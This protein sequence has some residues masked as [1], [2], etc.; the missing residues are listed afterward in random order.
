MTFS[1]E[2]PSY[3]LFIDWSCISPYFV[4][5]HMSILITTFLDFFLGN[6]PVKFDKIWNPILWKSNNEDRKYNTWLIVIAVVVN[7]III[8]A[9]VVVVVM[10]FRWLRWN[11]HSNFKDQ[12]QKFLC[13]E[14]EI[15]RGSSKLFFIWHKMDVYMK[16]A[17][18]TIWLVTRGYLIGCLIEKDA[19]PFSCHNYTQA[20]EYKLKIES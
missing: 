1:H 8:I 20:W 9:I 16:E 15:S 4:S 6:H 14:D 17:Y 2:E 10:V 13:K 5:Q 7:I 11:E 18:A 19:F 3:W 12:K